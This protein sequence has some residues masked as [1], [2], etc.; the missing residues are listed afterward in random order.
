MSTETQNLE[1]DP[2]A[3]KRR[4]MWRM[5]YADGWYTAAETGDTQLSLTSAEQRIPVGDIQAALLELDTPE[6]L[7]GR[8]P[9]WS[10]LLLSQVIGTR[11]LLVAST[12]W[13]TGNVHWIDCKGLTCP[14]RIRASAWYTPDGWEHLYALYQKGEIR[15]PWMAGPRDAAANVPGPWEL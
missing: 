5:T 10:T 1:P 2:A 13:S 9:G 6:T 3:T 8:E 15:Y 12:I 7:V 4:N 11:Y 14:V